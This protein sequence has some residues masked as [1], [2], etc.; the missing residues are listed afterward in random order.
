MIKAARI[1]LG[2]A[3]KSIFT[4]A[5]INCVVYI[6]LVLTFKYANLLHIWGLRMSNYA[7]LSLISILQVRQWIKANK[8][9]LPFLEAFFTIL[10][11]GALASLFFGGF[12]LVYSLYD[13]YL[14]TMYV[15]DPGLQSMVIPAIVLVLEGTGASIIVALIVMF[16]AGRFEEGEAKI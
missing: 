14:A 8:G 4:F 7:A 15:T 6:V 5:L 3:K 9:Y 13:P 16:Y 10:F 1:S 2:K 11:T 12:M